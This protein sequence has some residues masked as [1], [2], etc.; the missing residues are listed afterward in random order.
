MIPDTSLDFQNP[1]FPYP[2]L[3]YEDRRQEARLSLHEPINVSLE[4]A[5]LTVCAVLTNASLCGF[6]IRHHNSISLSQTF[7][8]RRADGHTLVRQVWEQHA[9]G[10]ATVGLLKEEVYLIHRLRSG[11]AE[12]IVQL[13][14]PHTETLRKFA[15]SILRSHEDTQDVLQEVVVKVLMHADQFHPGRSFKAWLMQ[16]TRNE[17]FKMLREFR[18]HQDV[19]IAGEE[20]E[21]DLFHE[22]NVP[23]NS[24]A[25]L[26]ECREIQFALLEAVAAL[27]TKYRQV[28]LLRH[29]LQLDMPDVARQLGIT[30]DNANT[31]LH[32]AH[33]A[34][35]SPLAALFR[36]RANV[37]APREKTSR[38]IGVSA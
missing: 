28:F 1:D 17:A 38:G 29:W 31:R 13:I 7:W 33:Q 2:A 22:L 26:V 20:D 23:R 24:P 10:L 16:I 27:E 25:D 32:R 21:G 36:P 11:H 19:V 6:Q 14:S 8:L 3:K 9:D 4:N 18:R 34:L 15:F 30:V 37:C 5:K 12:A 35:R